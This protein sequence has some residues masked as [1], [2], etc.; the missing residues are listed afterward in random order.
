VWWRYSQDLSGLTADQRRAV[1]EKG[2]HRCEVDVGHRLQLEVG[3]VVAGDRGEVV[4]GG[5]RAA[6]RRRSEELLGGAVTGGDAAVRAE[7]DGAGEPAALVVGDGEDRRAGEQRGDED[8]G[9]DGDG[10]GHA[11]PYRTG[12][13]GP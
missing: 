4:A 10:A 7:L 9:D 13:P 1:R 12:G 11:G 5:Q 8:G 3:L 2:H 6:V